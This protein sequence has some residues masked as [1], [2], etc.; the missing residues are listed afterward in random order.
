MES[1]IDTE[2]V[3]VEPTDEQIKLPDTLPVLPLRDIVIFPYMI[4]PLFVQRERS[5][6]AVDQA[7]AESR[8]IMLVAQRDLEKEE[9]GGD[10]L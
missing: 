3:R 7:L 8:M 2:E 1:I 9:P 10:D 4:V 6:R 5:I